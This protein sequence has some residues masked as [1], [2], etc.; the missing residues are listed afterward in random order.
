MIHTGWSAGLLV[1]W[2]VAAVP[3]ILIVAVVS[4]AV[5]ASVV[6]LSS[7]VVSESEPGPRPR[8]AGLV[9]D[10]GWR[11]GMGG[12]DGCTEQ[13]PE[14]GRWKKCEVQ[15]ALRGGSK[16]RRSAPLACKWCSPVPYLARSSEERDNRP[17]SVP[18][19]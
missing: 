1:F 7:P 17:S 4:L 6:S 16:G 15:E 18:G 19:Q 2:P 11:M 14:D 10:G 8:G 13:V 3:S 9:W 12:E 5:C